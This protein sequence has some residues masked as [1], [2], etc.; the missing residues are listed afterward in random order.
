[1]H[2]YFHNTTLFL[3]L[4]FLFYIPPFFFVA[5]ELR[6]MTV[7]FAVSIAII[8]F[9]YHQSL[10]IIRLNKASI[11]VFT[12]CVS[13]LVH[14]ILFIL[15]DFD[16]RKFFAII[17]IIVMFVVAGFFSNA[18]RKYDDESVVLVCK[19]LATIALLIGFGSLVL[20]FNYLNYD[21]YVKSIFPFSEPSHYVISVSSVFL[22]TGVFVKTWLKTVLLFLTILLG[23]LIPSL[24]LLALSIVMMVVFFGLPVKLKSILILATFLI[25]GVV[26]IYLNHEATDYSYFVDR[27]KFDDENTNLTALV[28]MQGWEKMINSLRSTN[29]VGVGLINMENTVPG[30]Y[31]ELIYSIAGKYLNRAGGSFVASKLVTEF[32]IVG[33]V[34]LFAYI[35]LLFKSLS[36][37]SRLNKYRR[38]KKIVISGLYAPANLIFAHSV[39]VVFAIELFARGV[40]YFSAGVF[41]FM[42]A[43]FLLLKDQTTKTKFYS[44]ID[45]DT[46]PW[47]E[48][49]R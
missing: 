13:L 36:F 35:V 27:I 21:K 1:M 26:L 30:Y 24:V 18:I 7:G 38:C 3:A 49:E 19:L 10:P 8:F 48:N 44:P 41:L 17:L 47:G 25:T 11:I 9:L 33:V 6:S 28:Y 15:L 20:D 31:G 46:T 39:I 14:A 5:F 34:M 37:F 12:L 42:M 22:A 29:G 4:F 45:L 40:G 32:G 2:T 23:V 16:L 43:I